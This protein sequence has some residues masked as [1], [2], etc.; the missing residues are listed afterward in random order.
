M[1][2]PAETDQQDEVA[3]TAPAPE[4]E[5]YHREEVEQDQLTPTA[6]EVPTSTPHPEPEEEAK[7][8][9][10]TQEEAPPEP[11]TDVSVAQQTR[12]PPEQDQPPA[13]SPDQTERFGA[14][15]FRPE[16]V[17]DYAG[18]ASR[19]HSNAPSFGKKNVEGAAAKEE[20]H[21]LPV[22]TAPTGIKDAI[23]GF[24]QR[25][26][27]KSAPAARGSV[28]G[29][30]EAA[31]PAKTRSAEQLEQELRI[32]LR[33]TTIEGFRRICF[34]S[35]KGGIGKS[36]L[37]YSAAAAISSTTNLRVCLVDADTNAGGATRYLVPHPVE[38]SVLD[39]ADDA[40]RLERLADLRTYVSQN[41]QMRLDVLLNPIES[42]QISAVEDLADAY[43]RV[44][45]V[46]SQF[47]DLV[48]YDLGPGFRDEAIRRVLGLS[49]ELVLI[50][51][52]DVIPNAQ[53]PDTLRYVE[54]LGINLQKTTLTIN[55]GRPPRDES[56]SATEIRDEFEGYVR[57]VTEVP[58]DATL[59]QLLNTRAFHIEK[60]ALPARLGVLTTAAAALE[61][62]RRDAWTNG[63]EKVLSMQRTL[64]AQHN[65]Q[66]EGGR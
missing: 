21:S 31:Q 58:Y 41:K 34:G 51:D 50:S 46:L 12:T 61:G 5:T 4:Q 15:P 13:P 52:A 66:K 36:S 37:A 49:D 65:G 20:S 43:A 53:L 64:P 11:E 48:I 19:T 28:S 8:A 29:A 22:S 39:L 24:V 30:G 57:R 9:A 2:G 42:A 45:A 59:S 1:G 60:L 38:Q 44:D 56:A 18:S 35:K 14:E 55:H 17:E 54:N 63:Y 40:E 7:T 26:S 23:Q 10:S 3:D 27:G 33:D 32:S 62:L 25:I 6:E 47:Y 16:P